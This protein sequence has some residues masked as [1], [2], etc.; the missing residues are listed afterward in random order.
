VANLQSEV[1]VEVACTKKKLFDI[2]ES[3]GFFFKERLHIT[4]YYFTHFNLAKV[5]VEFKEL[6]SN[7]MLIRNVVLERKY[8]SPEGITTL[9]YKKK[10]V[11]ECDRCQ[12]E[13]KIECTID[14]VVKARRIFTSMGLKNWI[15]KRI[16]AYVYKRNEVELF[17]QEVE[18]IGLFI[19]LEKY[20]VTKGGEDETK[21]KKKMLS[22]L[23]KFIDSL[24]VPI[25]PDYHV[26]IAHRMYMQPTQNAAP[27]KKPAVK[28]VAK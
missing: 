18:G 27:T 17:I 10:D 22:E 24:K 20:K 15:T 11:D 6:I 3:S 8:F 21:A 25:K 1:T 12:N 2:L 5:S 26:N 7:S 23:V 14:S 28:K 19:E 9:I 13:Q 16:T 4:D